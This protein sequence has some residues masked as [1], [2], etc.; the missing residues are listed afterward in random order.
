M[1]RTVTQRERLDRATQHAKRPDRTWQQA[2]T[3]ALQWCQAMWPGDFVDR[4]AK[5]SAR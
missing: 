1:R 5:A 2:R 4:P 3:I